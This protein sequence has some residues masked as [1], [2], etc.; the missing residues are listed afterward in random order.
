MNN[1]YMMWRNSYYLG[2][3]LLVLYA[4]PEVSLIVD[5]LYPLFQAELFPNMPLISA[6]ALFTGISAYLAF[7]YRRLG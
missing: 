7:K 3:L 1:N 6:I 2:I 5:Y 4:M